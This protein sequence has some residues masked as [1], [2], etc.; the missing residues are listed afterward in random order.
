MPTKNRWMKRD[1]TECAIVNLRK[2]GYR[3]A[4]SRR[5]IARSGG[6]QPKPMPQKKDSGKDSALDYVKKSTVK[7]VW[8]GCHHG[9]F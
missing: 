1:M 3:S 6:T 7:D 2:S 9:Y 5:G 8:K 4:G